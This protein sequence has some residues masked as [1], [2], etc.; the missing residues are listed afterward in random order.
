MSALLPKQIAEQY[1]QIL[2]N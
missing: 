1:Q 2:P